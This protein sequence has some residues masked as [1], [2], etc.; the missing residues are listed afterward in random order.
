M[1]ITK[2]LIYATLETF[3][4]K[5]KFVIILM[6]I[7]TY[8]HTN[9]I[10]FLLSMEKKRN[11]DNPADWML[12]GNQMSKCNVGGIQH[13]SC[14]PAAAALSRSLDCKNCRASQ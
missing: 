8:F 11:R 6:H 7:L 13:L 10:V 2:V 9:H 14:G 12:P 4:L 1:Y 3:Y 5:V